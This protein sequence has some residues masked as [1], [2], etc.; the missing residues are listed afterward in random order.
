M[1]KRKSLKR[2]KIEAIA[3][4]IVMIALMLAFTYLIAWAFNGAVQEN[5]RPVP[6]YML[7]VVK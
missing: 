7:E 1:K 2:R 4:L 5:S 6:A 3:K